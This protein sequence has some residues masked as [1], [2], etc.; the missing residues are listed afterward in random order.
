MSIKTKENTDGVKPLW[1]FPPRKRCETI[2]IQEVRENGVILYDVA[3]IL[4]SEPARRHLNS[5]HA[6][7]KKHEDFSRSK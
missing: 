5:L 2:K 3:S 7:V 6:L 1:G 4:A